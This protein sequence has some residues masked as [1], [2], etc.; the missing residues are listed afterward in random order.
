M[1]TMWADDGA[2][3]MSEGLDVDGSDHVQGVGETVVEVV[4]GGVARVAMMMV[5]AAATGWWTRRGTMR[6]RGMVGG[7]VE[8]IVMVEMTV[9]TAVGA[10]EVETVM[11][12]R[13]GNVQRR[14][15]EMGGKRR[16]GCEALAEPLV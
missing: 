15:F 2:V 3:Q 13:V 6:R 10:E 14:G 4:V 12:A 16:R 5:T 1:G 8:E 7:V 11:A 9:A